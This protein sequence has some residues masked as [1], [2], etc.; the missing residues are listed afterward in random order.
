MR[1]ICDTGIYMCVNGSVIIVL[2]GQHNEASLSPARPGKS[3]DLP[4]E[5]GSVGRFTK[6]EEALH[7][8]GITAYSVFVVSST[9][10]LFLRV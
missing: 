3:P 7:T 9:L 8:E 5:N 2:S 10:L 4:E 1:C 6:E